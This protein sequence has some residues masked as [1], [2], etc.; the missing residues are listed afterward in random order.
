MTPTKFMTSIR[1]L[2]SRAGRCGNQP[3]SASNG[4]VRDRRS[5]M[6]WLGLLALAFSLAP[7]GCSK[8]PPPADLGPIG[9]FELKDQAGKPIGSQE[10][11]GKV[12]VAAFMFTRCPTICPRITTRMRKL[13][14]DAA[15]KSVPLQLVSISVDPDN[16]TPD[17]LRA[18]AEQYHADQRSWSFATGDFK[19]IQQT[20]VNGF[21][22]ALDGHADPKAEGFGIVHGSHLVLV[23]PALHIRGYYRSDDESELARLLL[24]ARTIEPG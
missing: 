17:V 11:S 6:H 10:L 24:D 4:F 20:A 8:R 12:W 7:L 1:Q 22:L 14:E 13:Q 16:D 9:A 3:I 18:Y 15:S 19:I 2:G 23:D 21:K 5:M